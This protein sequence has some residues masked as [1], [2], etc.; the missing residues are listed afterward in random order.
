MYVRYGVI[1]PLYEW[2]LH[3]NCYLYYTFRAPSGRSW[4]KKVTKVSTVQYSSVRGKSVRTLGMLIPERSSLMAPMGD[5][6]RWVDGTRKP[7]NLRMPVGDDLTGKQF[8][9]G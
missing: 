5:C 2:R 1:E 3:G 7:V 6:S 9:N 4:Q 8:N